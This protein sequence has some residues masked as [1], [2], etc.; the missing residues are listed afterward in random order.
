MSLYSRQT[1]NLNP[2]QFESLW[3]LNHL[4]QNFLKIYTIPYLTR[5][6]HPLS[7]LEPLPPIVINRIPSTISQPCIH[8]IAANQRSSP[9]LPSITMYSYNIL[10]ILLQVFKHILAGPDQTNKLWSLMI[11]PILYMEISTF[12]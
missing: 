6:S 11:Y 1:L 12:K 3:Y 9:P 5:I 7:I 2:Q 4:F 10:I 8:Q